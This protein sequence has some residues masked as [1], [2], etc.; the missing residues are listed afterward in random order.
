MLTVSSVHTKFTPAEAA[1]SE[2]AEGPR[3]H[4]AEQ[5]PRS[6]SHRPVAHMLESTH[7]APAAPAPVGARHVQHTLPEHKDGPPQESPEGQSVLRTQGVATR[8][9]PPVHTAE[10]VHAFPGQQG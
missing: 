7:A 1:Q 6:E 4:V 5:P 8:H 3:E 10:P 9:V 2:S